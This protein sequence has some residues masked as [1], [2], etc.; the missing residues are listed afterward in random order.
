MSALQEWLRGKRVALAPVASIT[1]SVYRRLCKEQGADYCVTE[2]VSS[3]ALTRDSL[4]SYDLARFTAAERPIAV[5]IF[6]GEP[7]KLAA[8]TE[9]VNELQPDAIDIN[10]GCPARKVT[11]NAG[12]SDL[13]RDLPRLGRV[14]EAV[15]ARAAVPV[16]VKLRAGW[17]E[18]SLVAVEAAHIAESAG[19]QWLTLH[20][21]TRAQRFSGRARWELIAAVKDTVRIPVIGNG[22]IATA[23][24][25]MRMFETTGCDSVMIGRGSFGYPWIFAQVK[26]LLAGQPPHEPT[27]AERVEMALRNLS[28][29]LEAF[30]GLPVHAVHA[31]RKHLAWY[32]ADLPGSKELRTRVFKADI[33]RRGGGHPAALRRTGG[34]GLAAGTGRGRPGGP[35]RAPCR[36]GLRPCFARHRLVTAGSRSTTRRPRCVKTISDAPGRGARRAHDG[37]RRGRPS[38]A[39]CRSPT[40]AS[41]PSTI[42]AQM[43]VGMPEVIFCAGKTADEVAAIA[44]HMAERGSAVLGTRCAPETFAAVRERLPRARYNERGRVFRSAEPV[45]R[46]L[47][48]RVAVVTAG[49]PTAAWPR[50][51]WKRWPRWARPAE[52]V[53]DVGVA[54]LHRLLAHRDELGALRRADR[55]GRHGGGAG[56]RRGGRHGQAHHRRADE[57]RLRRELR[58]AGGAARHAE[59]LRRRASRWSTSTTASGRRGGGRGADSCGEP[60]D[61]AGAATRATRPIEGIAR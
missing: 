50:R 42:T 2:L 41:R 53:F 34:G 6:G 10:M 43:R 57:R 49:T 26:A 29:E 46:A 55:R 12:G 27:P 13:L 14:V 3:E 38:C 15:V 9:L 31:M 44:A 59:Q 58:R 61:S 28:L 47:R 45:P 36:G 24:D 52:S 11:R 51:R 37:G 19:A 20:P 4:H 8:A 39:T 32:V 54:G 30:D 40:W 21:R 48:G 1:N 35:G 22:D 25:A 23:A 56:E 60:P 17:D 18:Q 5:Q 16:S 7:E 33:V